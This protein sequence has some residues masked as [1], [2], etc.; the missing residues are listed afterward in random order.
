MHVMNCKNEATEKLELTNKYT[1]RY[2]TQTRRYITDV[3]K[4]T[5]MSEFSRNETLANY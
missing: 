2:D 4:L 1:Q 3:E 5:Q